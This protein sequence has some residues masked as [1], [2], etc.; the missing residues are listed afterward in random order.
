MFNYPKQLG[1]RK[2]P[3]N[4]SSTVATI[5]TGITS[6]PLSS[7]INSAL[8]YACFLNNKIATGM[9]LNR[10]NSLRNLT[11]LY[12]KH[13]IKMFREERRGIHLKGMFPLNWHTSQWGM[14][15]QHS[16]NAHTPQVST[17]CLSSEEEFLLLY[18]P[19]PASY[20]KGA[21]WKR[22]IDSR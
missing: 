18:S 16:G 19:R 11:A 15:S 6:S 22:E 20:V 8:F 5:L 1:W 21:L 7:V 17:S 14:V 4:A 13:T 3:Q 9:V 12:W 10:W 2:C